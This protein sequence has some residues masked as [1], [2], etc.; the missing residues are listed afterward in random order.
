MTSIQF[1]TNEASKVEGLAYAGFETFRG[2]PYTSC[3]RETGQNSR[4]AGRAS[5]VRVAFKLHYIARS[6][7]P[8]ADE[9]AHSIA[10][11]LDDPQDAKTKVHL[12]RALEAIF[13]QV[14]PRAYGPG[15]RAGGLGRLRFTLRHGP[16]RRPD[17]IERLRRQRFD[18][19]ALR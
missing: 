18:T 6:R 3:A 8:S 9:L 4:D 16:A 15:I 17:T 7:I 13:S 19:Q 5:P 12:E 14:G 2:S 10:C 11:C 1:L